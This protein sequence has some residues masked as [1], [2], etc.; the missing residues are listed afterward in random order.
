MGQKGDQGGKVVVV[1]LPC[2]GIGKAYGEIGRQAT[3]ALMDDLCPDKVT[4]TCLAK[5]MI[6]DPDAL[7]LVKNNTVITIDGC[8]HDCARKN[9]ESTGKKVDTAV[10]VINTF[11]QHK[12]LK[13]AGVL[14]LGEPG[15]KLAQILAEDLAAEIDCPRRKEE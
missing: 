14:E 2:S 9:V 10:R 12:D 11:K 7:D 1:V 8:A 15:F 3:Y 6:G 13:P 5:L 4:T